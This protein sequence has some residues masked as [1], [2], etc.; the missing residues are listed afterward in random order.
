M[1]STEFPEKEIIDYCKSKYPE[2]EACGIVVVVKGRYKFI[3]CKNIVTS[4]KDENFAIHPLDY[5][6]AEDEGVIYA[7]IHSHVNQNAV[8]SYVD[9]EYQ[10]KQ[11]TPWFL[12]GLLN[13]DV[14]TAWLKNPKQEQPLFGRKYIWQI[15]DCYSFIRDYYKEK[16]SIDLPDFYRDFEFWKS[17]KELYLEN[18]MEAGFSEIPIEDMRE[19]DVILLQLAGNVTSHGGIYING[20]KIAH[21]INGRLSS[22]DIYGK[23]YQDRTTKVVRHKELV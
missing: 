21:H 12:V 22:I 1:T 14:T 6:S 3:P 23:F 17:G 8:F 11:G 16:Y 13:G 19:G 4:H 2:E 18:F 7:I 15:Y 20:N 5:A 9:T 10:K